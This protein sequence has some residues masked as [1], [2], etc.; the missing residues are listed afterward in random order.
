MKGI[1]KVIGKDGDTIGNTIVSGEGSAVKYD[2]NDVAIRNYTA[3][4]GY[5][6][7]VDW[8]GENAIVAGSKIKPK[9]INEGIAYADKTE[10][11]DALDR[12]EKQNEIDKKPE[13]EREIK[14]GAME[15]NALSK[16]RERK[17]FSYNPETDPAYQ[18]YKKQYEREA[19]KA[20]RRILN[21]NNTSIEGASGAVLSEAIAAQNEQ[22]DKITDVIPQL[23]SDAYKRYT[24]EFDM[25]IDTLKSVSDIANA[26]YDRI[27]E[28]NQDTIERMRDSAQKEHD[29]DLARV[30]ERR[31][32]KESEIQNALDEID[33]KKGNIDL[34]YYADKLLAD[35]NK[36]NVSSENTAMKN[37]IS[38]GFFIKEDEASMPWLKNY[39]TAQGTYSISPSVASIAYE[40]QAAHE[41]E[42][43]KINA[44]LGR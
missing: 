31:L 12:M 35:I 21:D 40:Y 13:Q 25:D 1:I 17:P 9:Y 16:I 43:G 4:K 27:N 30:K 38:R 3:S 26:Y 10:V 39:R 11:D 32:E 34:G 29:N 33:I 41:R 36:T 24:G 8:D 14:Y 28:H 15:N 20:L 22:L 6:G 2:D 5:S 19:E 44:K 18:A 23:Y 7:I 42:R 37:A